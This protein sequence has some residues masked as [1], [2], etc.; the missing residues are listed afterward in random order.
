MMAAADVAILPRTVRF[1][2]SETHVRPPAEGIERCPYSGPL[3]AIPD[4]RSLPIWI[5]S[6]PKPEFFP[7]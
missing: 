6:V 1:A 5:I 7:G 4:G 3:V 2:V